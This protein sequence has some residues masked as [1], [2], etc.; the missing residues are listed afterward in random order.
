[1]MSS[2]GTDRGMLSSVGSITVKIG[3]DSS[4]FDG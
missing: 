3:I 2:G 1:M 4:R